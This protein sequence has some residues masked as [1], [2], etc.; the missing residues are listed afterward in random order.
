MLRAEI[1]SLLPRSVQVMQLWRFS[2]QD[3]PFL[4][5]GLPYLGLAIIVIRKG[6]AKGP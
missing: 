3:P 1:T 4:K 6:K 2:G 5:L